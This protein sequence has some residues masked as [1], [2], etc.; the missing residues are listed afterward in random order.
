M[1]LLLILAALG[2]VALRRKGAA[3]EP[4]V[5]QAAAVD[6]VVVET[7]G[8]LGVAETASAAAVAE[9]APDA[10]TAVGVAAAGSLLAPSTWANPAVGVVAAVVAIAVGIREAQRIQDATFAR[11]FPLMGGT[12]RRK[13]IANKTRG[14]SLN[15]LTNP[16]FFQGK[17]NWQ[18]SEIV[19]IWGGSPYALILKRIE[20]NAE[21]PTWIRARPSDSKVKAL[22]E[23]RAH[24]ELGEVVSGPG[25]Y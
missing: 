11:L 21:D 12:D 1:E 18:E 7:S 23:N 3:A 4:S 5:E 10:T 22:F 15:L 2:V 16:W 25:P 9:V 13:W 19:R 8:G 20:E 6:V 24:V 17:A 14:M